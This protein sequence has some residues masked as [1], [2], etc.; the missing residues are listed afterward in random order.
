MMTDVLVIGAGMSG[1]ACAHALVQAGAS[2]TVLE[3]APRPGGVVGTLE[4]DGFRFETGPNT[5]QAGSRTFR[6]LCGALGIADE[7]VVSRSEAK[8]RYLFHRGRLQALPKG[9]G[10]FLFS[11]LLSMRAKLAMMTEPLRRRRPT[12]EGQA[13]PTFEAFLNERIG[14]EATRTLAGAFVRGVYAAEVDQLGARSAFPRLFTMAQEH[15]GLM[16]GVLGARRA[17][18]GQAPP[19]PVPGPAAARTDLLSFSSGLDR[20]VTA[21]AEALGDRLRLSSCVRGLEPDGSGWIVTLENGERVSARRVVLAAPAG[22]T[23]ELLTG[24][25]PADVDLA[26]LADLDHA[27]VTVVHLGLGS[28]DLPEGFGFLVPPDEVGPEAPRA[29][30]VLFVSNIFPGRAPSGCSAVSA[31]YRSTD[32]E[33]RDEGGLVA[34]ALRDLSR[35]GVSNDPRVVVSRTQSWDGVIPRYGVGHAERM[36]SLVESLAQSCPSLQLAGTYLDGVSVEECLTR[37]RRIG[38]ELATN[39]EPSQE[40]VA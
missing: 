12:P 15:G 40:A 20:F 26:A 18:R 19:A 10:S 31:V 37:G 25:V 6:Q 22:I 32:L 9:P 8:L 29:L 16:R 5:L 27:A 23:A 39:S 36:Q 24:A 21:M 1:M 30:G 28:A 2:V 4:V 17:R 34:Q 11:P 7:L 38:R 33:A 13:E 35:A 3:A 14:R